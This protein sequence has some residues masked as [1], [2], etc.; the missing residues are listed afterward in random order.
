MGGYPGGGGRAQ[1]GYV[2]AAFSSTVSSVYKFFKQRTP[3]VVAITIF[4][5]LSIGL[6][7]VTSVP[8]VA[9]EKKPL[10]G[11]LHI[12]KSWDSS[13]WRIWLPTK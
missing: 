11:K 12:H 7:A 3:E 6:T 1:R 4:L 5:L 13:P 8:V 10:F 2:L 9:D